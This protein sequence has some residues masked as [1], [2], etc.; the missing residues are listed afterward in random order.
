MLKW[1]I[2]LGVG[3]FVLG[4][5]GPWLAR[6]GLGRMPGDVTVQ[7]NGRRFYFPVATS[8]VLSLVLM[9]ILRLLRI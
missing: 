7:R 8:I 2:T 4:L 5:V 3:I 1:L 6:L 9:L